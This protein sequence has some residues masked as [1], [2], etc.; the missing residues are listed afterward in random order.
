M[1]IRLGLLNSELLIFCQASKLFQCTQNPTT[2]QAPS[3]LSFPSE[4]LSLNQVSSISLLYLTW[5]FKKKG[6]ERS[7]GM[8]LT[9]TLKTTLTQCETEML[10]PERPSH[11]VAQMTSGPARSRGPSGPTAH[12]IAAHPAKRFKRDDLKIW[13]FEPFT[14]LW[15]LEIYQHDPLCGPRRRVRSPSRRASNVDVIV[16]PE[17]PQIL[18]T[19]SSALRRLFLLL[20]NP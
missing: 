11:I 12:A 9:T 13:P 16:G 2:P 8:C 15:L 5:R 20:G 19:S 7:H 14:P 17:R 6:T 18:S 3:F 4:F 1:L 10:G